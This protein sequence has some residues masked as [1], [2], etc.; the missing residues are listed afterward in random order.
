MET[1][2]AEY[3]ETQEK[4]VDNPAII[5]KAKVKYD[6][7]PDRNQYIHAINFFSDNGGQNS[8]LNLEFCNYRNREDSSDLFE[9][10]GEQII[11]ITVNTKSHSDHISRLGFVTWAP[12]EDKRLTPERKSSLTNKAFAIDCLFNIWFLLF[13]ALPMGIA[14]FFILGY[15]API[16][17]SSDGWFDDCNQ[18]RSDAAVARLSWNM[19]YYYAMGAITF[20][21]MPQW[22]LFKF[23]FFRRLALTSW[24]LHVPLFFAHLTIILLV[25]AKIDASEC[26]DWHTLRTL[27]W[28]ALAVTPIIA[29]IGMIRC[30]RVQEHF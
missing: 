23:H 12:K 26:S 8:M 18:P 30:K 19:Y 2:D 21:R 11:G 1:K 3:W 14:A 16:V 22:L 25:N 24:F 5:K 29:F 9:N 27:E 20:L 6:E 4:S 13:S 7:F 10:S 17:L 15:L 28:I